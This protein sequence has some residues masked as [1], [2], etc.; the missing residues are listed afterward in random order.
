MIVTRLKD[1]HALHCE[2]CDTWWSDLDPVPWGLR[3]VLWMHARGCPDH[4]VRMH[5]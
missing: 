2:T 4:V 3:N 5:G 1:A